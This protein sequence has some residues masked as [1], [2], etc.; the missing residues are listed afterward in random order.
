MHRA[1]K[2]NLHQAFA[3]FPIQIAFQ[4]DF[5]FDAMNETFSLYF[6]VKAVFAMH[7]FLRKPNRDSLQIPILAPR[8]HQKRHRSAAA[9]R[10]QKQSIRVWSRAFASDALRFVNQESFA[11]R[12]SDLIL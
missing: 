6:A 5:A 10:S 9:E 2:R 8:V 4:R 7:S 1:G 3:L 12:V 11:V